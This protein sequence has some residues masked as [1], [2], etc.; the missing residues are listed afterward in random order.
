MLLIYEGKFEEAALWAERAIADATAPGVPA[1]LRANLR[2]LLGVIHLRRGETENCLECLGPSS[3]IFPIAAEA[4]HQNTS[5]SR[6]AIRHFREY[7]RQRPEDAGVRWLVNLAYMTLGE[8]PAKVPSDLLISLESFRSKLDMGRFENVASS[9]GL[10]LRGPNMA[11]GSV[12]DDFTG[13]GLPDIFSTSMD[14]DLGASLFVNRGDGT[15][16]DKSGSS[17]LKSQPYSV[18]CAQADFDNDGR[19]DV[20]LVRGGWESPARLTLLRNTGD[21]VFEDVTV[22]AGLDVPI[23]SHSA[24]WADFDND[25]HLDL[26]VCGEYANASSDNLFNSTSVMVADTRNLCRLYRNKG[27]GTFVNVAEQAGVRNYRFAK[28]AV[29]IDYDGDRLPDIYVSNCGQE[30]RLYHN[31]GNWTFEDLA[32]KL[33]VTDPRISFT[34]GVLDF[35]NDGRLDIF[36]SDYTGGLNAWATSVMNLPSKVVSHPRLFKNMGVSGFKDVSLEVGLDKVALAMGMGVGDIDNDGFLD[37]YLGTGLP[38]YSALMPNILY[39]NCA[40][41]R[42]ED[43]T[44]SSGT[45]H[46]QKGHGSSFADWDCDGDLDLFVEVGGAVPGDKAYN[47]LFQNPGHGRHWLKVKLV[48]T[49]TNR[50]ALGAT[51]RLDV[52]Q[53]G[54]KTRSVHR[55][56]G[57]ASSYGGSTLVETIGLDSATSIAAL[58]VNWPVSRTTQTF[59]NL[60]PDTAIE[61]T[62]GSDVFQVLNLPPLTAPPKAQHVVE[63]PRYPD[64]PGPRRFGP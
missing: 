21:G 33:D 44:E 48:G 39:K 35:D 60:T 47:L 64:L 3:C 52:K 63:Y 56:V 27:D 15:F 34:C 37:L 36:V 55:T 9:V 31:R 59:H 28:A 24:A 7:L 1:G 42:F 30:N 17:G 2:A 11:G 29:C 5:G 40:G 50:A 8:Y 13:D 54:G 18:N 38:G 10:G 22:A 53:A 57:N 41:Q 19:L 43:I 14:V 51:I 45:G 4:V 61:V 32:A 12:F 46:L 20:V 58:T 6:E 23:A 49:Q 25:G 62:E 16:E 26:F